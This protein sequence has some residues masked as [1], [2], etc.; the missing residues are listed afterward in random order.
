VLQEQRHVGPKLRPYARIIHGRPLHMS[1]S[2][3]IGNSRTTPLIEYGVNLRNFEHDD[4][5]CNNFAKM[6]Y[7]RSWPMCK[8]YQVIRPSCSPLSG[9]YNI[10]YVLLR[11]ID[12][13][14]LRLSE[15]AIELRLS[16]SQ[17]ILVDG[18]K[19]LHYPRTICIFKPTSDSM[20]EHD[21]CKGMT[22]LRKV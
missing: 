17:V 21:H 8:H 12:A 4:E 6:L 22:R 3:P 19:E 11:T 18:L 10:I 7:V 9:M 15:P 5:R 13:Y 2:S 1:V 16:S 20:D 14:L